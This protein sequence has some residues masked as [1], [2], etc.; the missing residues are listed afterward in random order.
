MDW[1]RALARTCEPEA[2]CGLIDG[3]AGKVIEGVSLPDFDG[4]TFW[5]WAGWDNEK[6]A[7]LYAGWPVAIR[8]AWTKT[9]TGARRLAL[10]EDGPPGVEWTRGAL[11]IAA[12]SRRSI[13]ADPRPHHPLAPIVRAWTKRPLGVCALERTACGGGRPGGP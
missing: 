11:G 9:P 6:P 12:L 7:H 2:P 8:T 10:D 13:E 4:C 5:T 1:L 3:A